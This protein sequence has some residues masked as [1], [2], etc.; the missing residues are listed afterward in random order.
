MIGQVV[1]HYKMLEKLGEGGMG[2][3]Y[4][5]ED[6]KLRRTVAV[7]FLP[8]R[9]SVHS[10]E[11]ERFQH[12]AQAASSLN[13]P[14]ICTIYEIDEIDDDTFIVM[15]YID[16]VTLREWIR[17]KAEQSEG[18]RK[19]GVKEAV[20]I[21]TEIAEGLEKA[22][23]KGIIHRDIKSE[24]VMVTADGRAK[25]MDFGLAKLR[26]VS[27]LTKTGSTIGT[28]AYM[29]PEQV[30][31]LETDHRTDIF[32]FGV[33]LYE[34][35]S[36][37]LP[38]RA[39]HETAM[40]YE[41]I[42]VDPKPVTDIRQSVDAEL[43]RIVM[44]CLEKDREVRYQSMREVAV[45]LKRYKRDSQGKKLER[46][47][48]KTQEVGELAYE[49]MPTRKPRAP[50]I[51]AG[52]AIALSMIVLVLFITRQSS[53]PES[54]LPEARITRL[55][56]QPGL[57]DE[58]TWS[59]DGK[60]LAYT[61]DD[62]G[63]Y[64]IVV[65]PIGGGQ[66]IRV[67]DDPADD[68]QPAWSPDGSKIA[69][70]SARDHG[71]KLSLILNAGPV[72]P[73]IKGKGGDIYLVPS[74]G[75]TPIKLVESG[76]DPAW[77]PDGKTIVFRS[78]RAG[79]WDIWI[80]PVEGGTP[81]QLTND[82]DIDYQPN[83][84]PDGTWILYGS[85][86]LG[87]VRVIPA[88]GGKPKNLTND[89]SLVVKPIWS[90][91][92]KDIIF[93]STR[94]GSMNIW[95]TLFTS[96][97]QG[98]PVPT[99]VTIGEGDNVNVAVAAAGNKI[100]FATVKSTGDIWELSFPSNKLRHISSETTTEDRPRLSQDGKTLLVYSDRTGNVELWTMD[101]NGNLLSQLTSSKYGDLMGTW[102]PDG[103]RFAY[104]QIDT[105]GND[106]LFIR[107]VGGVSATLIVE[108]ASEP[109]W[110]PDGKK[111]A[112]GLSK[113]GKAEIW[114]YSF[115]TKENKQLVSIE[116][117]NNLP[118][119]SPDGKWIAFNTEAQN[120]RQVWIVSSSGGTPRQITSGESEY[121]HPMWSPRDMDVLVCLKDHKNV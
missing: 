95:K 47:I 94:S 20:E 107:S 112:F 1:S 30:E 92:G 121:S 8:K 72:E 48:S 70:V 104:I 116:V 46:T 65:M 79:Q 77:S 88:I 32:S 100:A 86:P 85:G 2:I 97:S 26:G 87:E 68:M 4:K 108:S 33:V 43:S 22:H 52:A 24:N 117:S 98:I 55:T 80:V 93:S 111:L 17:R 5:A 37:Q 99:R 91:D 36:G 90:P 81:K 113:N 44:K 69:F 109:A 54:K 76:F 11:R 16:G 42:N 57:E 19:L 119:W 23:E 58:P 12:E 35:L 50:Y 3:V 120:S 45:D 38:F 31:G 82:P 84:S 61:S 106:K 62:R 59:P 25:I 115:E 96:N 56:A 49:Q 63:N 60:F 78:I 105:A 118:T 74:F 41:I 39:E 75:G 9:L 18:Y 83:W 67:I 14:N 89:K 6:A 73:Y 110:S 102:S 71:G 28:I 34:M 21:A 101:L 64:D 40:M 114:I 27:K 53:P 103:K 10:D 13:H 29:S 7:K 66:P 51:V 15:E